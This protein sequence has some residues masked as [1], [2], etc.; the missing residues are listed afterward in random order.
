MESPI[1]DLLEGESSEDLCDSLYKFSLENYDLSQALRAG[2]DD[3]DISIEPEDFDDLH[4]I[5]QLVTLILER[6]AREAK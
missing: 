3:D 6:G 1:G 2:G 4:S 5:G